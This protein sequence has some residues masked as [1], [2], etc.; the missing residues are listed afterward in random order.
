MCIII[1]S[2][3]YNTTVSRYYVQEQTTRNVKYNNIN[4]VR[5]IRIYRND[6]AAIYRRR[7]CRN[8]WV[9]TVDER[10]IY[11]YIYIQQS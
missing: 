8:I 11:I 1:Y 6:S 4:V 5:T 3:Y 10:A 9:L 7:F 2:I